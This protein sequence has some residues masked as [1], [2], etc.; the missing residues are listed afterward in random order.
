MQ[1]PLDMPASI[2]DGLVCIGIELEQSL[3]SSKTM[4][5]SYSVSFSFCHDVIVRGRREEYHV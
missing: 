5:A 3:A 1:K 2:P 4:E